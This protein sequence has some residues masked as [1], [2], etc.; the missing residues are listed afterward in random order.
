MKD[1]LLLMVSEDLYMV[2]WQAPEKKHH[3]KVFE[4]LIVLTTV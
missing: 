1:L 3:G 2:D 4:R